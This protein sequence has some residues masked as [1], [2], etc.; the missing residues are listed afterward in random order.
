MNFCLRSAA[1]AEVRHQAELL[2]HAKEAFPRGVSDGSG[3]KAQD[4]SHDSS[5]EDVG[6]KQVMGDPLRPPMN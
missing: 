5:R 2:N 6:Y 1:S 4:I 3:Y